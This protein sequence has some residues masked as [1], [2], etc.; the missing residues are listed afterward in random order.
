[1]NKTNKMLEMTDWH[2][3]NNKTEKANILFENHKK[4]TKGELE[5]FGKNFTKTNNGY[6]HSSRTE[7]KTTI[8][9][10]FGENK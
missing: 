1:M 7:L 8:Y 2:S 10:S 5:E 4:I 6:F 3:F 9:V